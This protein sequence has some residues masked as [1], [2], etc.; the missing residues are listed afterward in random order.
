MYYSNRPV[1]WAQTYGDLPQFFNDGKSKS[2]IIGRNIL[3]SISKD[4][5]V[6]VLAESGPLLYVR[7]TRLVPPQLPATP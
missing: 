6:E 7:M 2:V 4:Y 5:H 3:D 1:E